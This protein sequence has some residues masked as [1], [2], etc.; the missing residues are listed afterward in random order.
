MSQSQ[1]KPSSKSSTVSESDDPRTKWVIVELSSTAEHEMDMPT[2][3]RAARRI[4]GRPNAEVFIPAVDSRV[5]E[6]SQILVYMDGYAF[7]RFEPGV[8]YLKLR[9]TNYFRDVLCTPGRGPRGVPAYSLLDDSQLNPMREGMEVIGKTEFKV[10]DHVKVTQGENKNLPG[11]VSDILE[12][13]RILVS[14][15]LRSKPLILPYP[16]S[17]L[18]KIP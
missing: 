15:R 16:T 17:Y 2:I 9:D 14:A 18:Q 1:K 13:G 11:Y 5:R 3:T 4:L 12:D 8:N 10:G 7:V 6:D